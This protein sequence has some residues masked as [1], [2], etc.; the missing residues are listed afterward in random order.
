MTKYETTEQDRRAVGHVADLL[1]A[2]SRDDDPG[3][4]IAQIDL[5]DAGV[6]INILGSSAWHWLLA[7]SP[8]YDSAALKVEGLR[9]LGKRRP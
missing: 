1:A 3:P 7:A 6:V 4:V 2:L 8:S 5:D 9:R